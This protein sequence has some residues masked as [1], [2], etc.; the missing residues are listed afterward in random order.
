MTSNFLLNNVLTYGDRRLRGV[1][2][3]TGLVSFYLICSLGALAN[4]G[5]ASFVFR[6]HYAWWLAG[7]AG[8]I[9]GTVWNYAMSNVFTWG[10]RRLPS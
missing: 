3:L 1:S 10:E 8:V 4:V 9:V 5:I 2:L 7:I 6:Q